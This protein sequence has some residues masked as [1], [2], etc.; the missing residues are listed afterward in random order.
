MSVKMFSVPSNKVFHVHEN[1]QVFEL[2]KERG[3]AAVELRPEMTRVSGPP[4]LHIAALWFTYAIS[5][6]SV[7]CEAEMGQFSSYK[8]CTF[9]F[10][11]I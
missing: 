9:F 5:S 3:M 2:Q 8:P 7:V 6:T 10:S 11:Q 4:G 1:I